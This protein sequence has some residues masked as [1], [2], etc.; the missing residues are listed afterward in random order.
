[1]ETAGRGHQQ[2]I[3][4]AVVVEI[5]GDE[6][7]A[8]MPLTE[9]PIAQ[10]AMERV[11]TLIGLNNKF[12]GEPALSISLGVSTGDKSSDLESIMRAADDNMYREKRARRK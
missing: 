3:G 2:Q 12:Y 7:A 10:E 6:F 11:Q 8:I 1:M 5:G 9:S 4:I